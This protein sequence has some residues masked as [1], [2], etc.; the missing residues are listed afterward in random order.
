MK[1]GGGIS[2]GEFYFFLIKGEVKKGFVLNLFKV[3]PLFLYSFLKE[4]RLLQAWVFV[5]Y[6]PSNDKDAQYQ[7]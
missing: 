3:K 4:P 6:V 2:W 7:V 5:F 1:K